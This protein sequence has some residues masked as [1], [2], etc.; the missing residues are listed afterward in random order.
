MNCTAH[1]FSKHA[2]MSCVSHKCSNQSL[3]QGFRGQNCG[4]TV[5]RRCGTHHPGHPWRAALHL[6]LRGS[7]QTQ[8]TE[9]ENNVHPGH[10]AAQ[11]GL[12]IAQGRGTGERDGRRGAGKAAGLFCFLLHIALVADSSLNEWQSHSRDGL[13][14]EGEGCAVNTVPL[15]QNAIASS[16]TVPDLFFNQHFFICSF[17]SDK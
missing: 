5:Q 1:Y 8:G 16:F 3:L 2:V 13:D 4:G 14:L 15:V 10:P 12:L 9:Q 6:H 11:P 17:P 7:C